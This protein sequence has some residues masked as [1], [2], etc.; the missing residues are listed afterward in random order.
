MPHASPKFAG[1]ILW[2]QAATPLLWDS[3]GSQPQG[4][5]NIKVSLWPLETPSGM[6]VLRKEVDALPTASHGEAVGDSFPVDWNSKMRIA[7]QLRKGLGPS[8]STH[9]SFSKSG[10]LPN[11]TLHRKAPRRS[12]GWCCHAMFYLSA[13]AVE[14]ILA[15]H[16]RILRYG[17]WIKYGL[18]I[19]QIKM[20][21]QRKP[22]RNAP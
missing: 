6:V 2:L 4:S 19:R 16:G 3:R 13:F 21:G 9:F 1:K 5:L 8:Q 18:W 7:G 15:A 20:N 14:S 12:N 10:Y 22:W 17:L 11:H